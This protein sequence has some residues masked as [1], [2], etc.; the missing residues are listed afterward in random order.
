MI[1]VSGVQDSSSV[2]PDAPIVISVDDAN[3]RDLFW[4]LDSLPE[5]HAWNWSTLHAPLTP[6]WHTLVIHAIDL[7]GNQVTRPL[8][9][10]VDAS[11]PVIV[12]DQWVS[13]SVGTN[14]Q[15]SG[16]ITDDFAV[17]RASLHY[18]VQ[19]GSFRVQ[20]ISLVGSAFSLSLASVN[21]WNG[22]AAYLTAEDYVGH[23][24]E[25]QHIVIMVGSD[26]RQPG[27]PS[28]P[29]NPPNDG[30]PNESSLIS[31]S[32]IMTIG[33]LAGSFFVLAASSCS[34]ILLT[35]K[36]R[37]EAKWPE[38][39]QTEEVTEV[40][41]DVEPEPEYWPPEPVESPPVS[42]SKPSIIRHAVAVGM[43]A[44]D[45]EELIKE[46]VEPEPQPDQPS[47]LD[48]VPIVPLT[49]KEGEEDID[50]GAIIERELNDVLLKRSVFHKD[51]GDADNFDPIS[52]RPAP[53]PRLGEPETIS[54]IK[55]RKMFKR[56][57]QGEYL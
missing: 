17:A 3:P 4:T 31:G 27:V 28:D 14:L 15:L 16:A 47:I 21:L 5:I 7:A 39:L 2:A 44:V 8:T 19:S 34:V 10:F 36:G 30:S 13:P 43:G 38:L 22:M 46:D 26:G 12:I 11:P 49:E 29:A 51:P 20:S 50:Y 35:R 48:T 37:R 55:L 45:D 24:S 54:G 9:F 18:Q 42:V 53:E 52:R 23:L 1:A 40:E 33:M 57:E 6:G 56:E 41:E 25:S 32:P